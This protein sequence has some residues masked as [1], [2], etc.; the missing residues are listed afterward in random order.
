M[1]ERRQLRWDPDRDDLVESVERRLG[2]L[3]LG[4]TT[5]RPTPGEATTAALLARVRET[6][7]AVLP[8]DGTS[9]RLRERVEFL[10]HRRGTPWPD[11]SAE[12]L[13]EN[14]DDWLVPYLAGASTRDDLERL[15]LTMLLRA[16]LPWPEGADLDALAPNGLD[17]PAGTT[18]RID[19]RDGRPICAV[20]V[21]DL[22]GL[23]EHP[24][25]DG[26]PIVLELLSPADRPIQVTSD[27]PGFWSGSWSA[28]RSEMV[29]RYPKHQWPDDP[30]TARPHR[31]RRP[32]SEDGRA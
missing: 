16:M 4:T 32:P 8:W 26:E 14:L 6:G 31:L 5:S 21:Q 10:R 29:G 1:T 28:V 13:L 22:F 20:R 9:L 2:S 15:D 18:A 27:L 25:A 30:A 3:R 24:L 7:L 11:W 12:A 19:Y 23:T 17:T